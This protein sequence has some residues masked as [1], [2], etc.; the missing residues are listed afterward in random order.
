MQ[1]HH[2]ARGIVQDEIDIV[3]RDDLREP[4]GQIMKQP[5][6]VAMY[7]NGFRHLEKSPV[8]LAGKKHASDM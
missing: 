3:E 7:R 2:V 6:Q 8:L 5:V 1:A 4:L